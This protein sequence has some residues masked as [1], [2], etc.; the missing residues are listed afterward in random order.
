MWEISLCA[1]VCSAGGRDSPVRTRAEQCLSAWVSLPVWVF[2]R[3]PA[4]RVWSALWS[5]VSSLAMASRSARSTV[6][7]PSPRWPPASAPRRRAGGLSQLSSLYWYIHAL[8]MF[9]AANWRL[10]LNILDWT[11]SLAIAFQVSGPAVLVCPLS[12]ALIAS[13]AALLLCACEAQRA[14]DSTGQSVV[15]GQRRM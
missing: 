9:T 4:G 5:G 14:R 1:C 13:G 3:S 6:A 2:P 12:T 8:R 10:N 15:S 7:K 11:N